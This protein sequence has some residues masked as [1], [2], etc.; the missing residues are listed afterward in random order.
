MGLSKFRVAGSSRTKGPNPNTRHLAAASDPRRIVLS[1]PIGLNGHFFIKPVSFHLL[2]FHIQCVAILL[3]RKGFLVKGQVPGA[4][5]DDFLIQWHFTWLWLL[6]V[7]HLCAMQA[8]E[9][10]NIESTIVTQKLRTSAE[11]V[12]FSDCIVQP[13][14]RVLRFKPKNWT[15]PPQWPDDLLPSKQGTGI[16][17]ILCAVDRASRNN[18]CK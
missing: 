5:P 11:Q 4:K 16:S 1:C 18:S 6:K 17:G 3:A 12:L 14:N 7:P 8:V 2:F 13:S 15:M 10:F 9:Y